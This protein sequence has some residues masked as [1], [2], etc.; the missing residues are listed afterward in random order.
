MK[1]TIEI[2]LPTGP[3]SQAFIACKVLHTLAETLISGVG[4]RD[5]NNNARLEGRGGAIHHPDGH[6]VGKWAGEATT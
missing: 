1:L 2:E 6:V 4:W 3:E 5:G